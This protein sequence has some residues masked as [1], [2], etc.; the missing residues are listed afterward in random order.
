MWAWKI[1]PALAVGCTIVMKPSELTPLTS[2][3]SL[4][5]IFVGPSV[6]VAPDRKLQKPLVCPMLLRIRTLRCALCRASR[7]FPSR[8]AQPPFTVCSR[9]PSAP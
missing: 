3:V 1:A 7:C 9:F 4:P 5:F 6:L 2:L 8:A